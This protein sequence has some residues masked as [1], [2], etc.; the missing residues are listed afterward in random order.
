MQKVQDLSSKSQV[1]C[2]IQEP[3]LGPQNIICGIS[4]NLETFYSCNH[5]RNRAIIVSTKGLHPVLVPSKTDNDTVTVKVKWGDKIF[6]VT[7]SY[8]DINENISGSK[9]EEICN[10][11][12]N[13]IIAVDSNSHSP[14]WGSKDEN[15]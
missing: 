1:I 7:S 6:E 12:T 9:F 8:L 3:W 15:G 13:G 5:S 11:L 14:L 4:S 10:K 2:L